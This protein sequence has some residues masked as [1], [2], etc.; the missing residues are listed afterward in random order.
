MILNRYNKQFLLE[1]IQSELNNQDNKWGKQMHTIYKWLSIIGV[2]IGELHKEALEM[3]DN[4]QITWNSQNFRQE[5][6]QVITLL[7]RLYFT[8][9][10]R[11]Y[12]RNVVNI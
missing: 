7:V 3:L 4:K 11:N 10:E 8:P 5:L 6:I 1:K 9:Y 2:E 12:K